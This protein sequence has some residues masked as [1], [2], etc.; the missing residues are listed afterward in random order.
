VCRLN[1]AFNLTDNSRRH[2]NRKADYLQTLEAEVTRLQHV[3]AEITSQKHE[4]ARQNHAMQELLASRSLDKKLPA[5]GLNASHSVTGD[6]TKSGGA[7]V[8]I[9]FDPMVQAE[10]VFVDVGEPSG[11]EALC[12]DQGEDAVFDSWL[13]LDFVLALEW[14]C[15]HRV[16]HAGI[17]PNRQTPL[18]CG[19]AGVYGLALTATSA[20]FA[21]AQ[22]EPCHHDMCSPSDIDSSLGQKW[23][24]P[25]AEIEK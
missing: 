25:Y 17:N 14:P 3:D 16:K 23:Q 12:K 19:V 15:R 1:D 2:R 22:K 6:V 20:V 9:R 18:A 8:V 13:A 5:V 7:P 21:C 10:R 24:I 4:L 11:I